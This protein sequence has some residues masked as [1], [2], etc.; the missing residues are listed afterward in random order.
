[1]TP[2]T[3]DDAVMNVIH[4]IF[5]TK[6]IIRIHSTNTKCIWTM[7]AGEDTCTPIPKIS[8]STQIC[9]PDS[10]SRKVTGQ[11][12]TTISD[13]QANHLAEMKP[14]YR[15]WYETTHPRPYSL[16]QAI[17]YWINRRRQLHRCQDNNLIR[18][19]LS[20]RQHDIDATSSHPMDHR[21]IRGGKRTTTEQEGNFFHQ[22][23]R[24][25][26]PTTGV[27]S[28]ANTVQTS[29]AKTSKFQ[30]KHKNPKHIRNISTIVDTGAQVTTMLESERSQQDA[31]RSRPQ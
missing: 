31:Q 5:S 15:D 17:E 9:N 23:L 16:D 19:A 8:N 14:I 26:K 2:K 18:I 30:C 3:R 20:D 24:T 7:E 1:M 4:K 12:I 22:S 25:P 10:N 11:R 27:T 6:P 29:T 28:N 13:D 21:S